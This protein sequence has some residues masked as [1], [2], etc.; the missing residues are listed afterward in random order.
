MLNVRWKHLTNWYEPGFALTHGA[1]GNGV[2]HE[3]PILNVSVCR[4]VSLTCGVTVAAA[5]AALLIV[6]YSAELL[7]SATIPVWGMWDSTT[8]TFKL[9]T[10]QYL[11]FD[12]P[13]Y[14]ER[15]VRCERT[16]S[17]IMATF[18]LDLFLSEN[19]FL[20]AI[21]AANLHRAGS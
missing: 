10:H 1:D 8:P 15:Y 7:M 11:C 2:E 9:V 14:T 16:G 12:K 21:Q 6:P 13:P 5:P 4:P 19:I 18:L 17:Q 3:W 20:V